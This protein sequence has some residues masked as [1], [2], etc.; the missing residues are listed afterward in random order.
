[1]PQVI[2]DC[3]RN[4]DN[5]KVAEIYTHEYTISELFMLINIQKDY[6]DRYVVIREETEGDD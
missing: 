6:L 1:M 3:H 2:I 4:S 5:R